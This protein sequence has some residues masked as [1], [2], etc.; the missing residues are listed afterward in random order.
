MDIKEVLFKN[1]KNRVSLVKI[2]HTHTH[3]PQ[4]IKIQYVIWDC[5]MSESPGFFKTKLLGP[6][7]I[8]STGMHEEGYRN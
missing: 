6:F 5:G 3:T 4:F 8:Y 2:L 1:A 7:K